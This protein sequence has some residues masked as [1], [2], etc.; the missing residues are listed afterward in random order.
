M[1][2]IY[3][4]VL[5][6]ALGVLGGLGYSIYPVVMGGFDEN[7]SF[8]QLV[9]QG[10]KLKKSP[11][12]RGIIFGPEGQQ[13]PE[14]FIADFEKLVDGTLAPIGVNLVIFD[15]HWNN[16]H[17][18]TVPGLEKV[19][20]APRFDFTREHAKRMAD[21]CHRNGVKVGVGINFLTHQNYGQLLKAFPDYQWPGKENLWD[22]LNPKVNPV[23]FKMADELIDAFSAD[24]IHL[25]MDEAWGFDLKNH[26]DNPGLSNAELL[27]REIKQYHQH[28]VEEKGKEMILWSDTLEGRYSDAPVGD[29]LDRIPKDIIL[30]HWEYGR[31]M[32]YPWPQKLIDKGFRVL[33]CPW[34][35]PVA[36]QKLAMAGL[37]TRDPK[38][39]GILY[40]TWS[41]SVAT[42]LAGALRGEITET[43][44]DAIVGVAHTIK[45][46]IGMFGSAD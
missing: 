39:L 14:D 30:A 21:I 17:F 34:K 45:R 43:P 6:V 29:V 3:L 35:D 25:G 41:P 46:T 8:E 12:W 33:V 7:Q 26:P 37:A 19:S 11:Q 24:V 1:K 15:M 40:T 9:E 4:T 23:A 16:F 10:K 27:A 18:T 38:M 22:P 36:G 31:K 5:V 20:R 28:F 42:K 32:R 13:S 44:K 2:G